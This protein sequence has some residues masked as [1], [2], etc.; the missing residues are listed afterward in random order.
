MWYST[1]TT[2][3]VTTWNWEPQRTWTTSATSTSNW[4]KD[5]T[6]EFLRDWIKR[7][8]KRKNY[9]ESEIKEDEILN[10]IKGDK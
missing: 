4:D 5:K 6:A 2:A 9:V 8:E 7:Q 1:P 10:L 3:T